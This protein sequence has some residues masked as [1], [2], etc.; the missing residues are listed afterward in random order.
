MNTIKLNQQ[1]MTKT[2]SRIPLCV[3]W[4]Q[5]KSAALSQCYSTTLGVQLPPYTLPW[6]DY[7][8]WHLAMG[9]IMPEE[10]VQR[11]VPRP[12]AAAIVADPANGIAGAPEISALPAN[13]LGGINDIHEGPPTMD[14]LFPEGQPT[15]AR[16]TILNAAIDKKKIIV[17]ADAALKNATMEVLEESYINRLQQRTPGLNNPPLIGMSFKQL[18]N[19]ADEAFKCQNHVDVTATRL[20][21]F[22][23]FTPDELQDS[24]YLCDAIA[25]KI[26]IIEMVPPYL[27]PSFAGN[28]LEMKEMLTPTIA[29]SETYNEF[30]RTYPNPLVQTLALFSDTVDRYYDSKI[31]IHGLGHGLGQATT[32]TKKAG[33]TGSNSKSDVNPM[34]CKF[35]LVGLACVDPLTCTTQYTHLPDQFGI[36]RGMKSFLKPKEDRRNPDKKAT[37]RGRSQDRKPASK[38]SSKDKKGRSPSAGRSRANSATNEEEE[39]AGND[40][41]ESTNTAVT[42][43]DK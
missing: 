17:A 38:D 4:L 16:V 21:V 1:K 10:H 6:A 34:A 25:R 7:E 22:T 35:H 33:G 37:N 18:I 2:N 20:Y 43:N 26:R 29:L 5:I 9:T 40:D 36:G 3:Q 28:T 19:D 39:D 42:A 41:D 23:P 24:R 31:A 30:N 14:Q 32:N 11:F 15:N 13:P 8:R 12:F 27:R